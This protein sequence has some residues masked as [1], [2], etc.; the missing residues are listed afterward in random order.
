MKIFRA[1]IILINL[2]LLVSIILLST[3]ILSNETI[4]DVILMP[5]FIFSFY[6]TFKFIRNEK[7]KQT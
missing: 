2:L 6:L 1:S 5:A 3:D 4:R 7:I